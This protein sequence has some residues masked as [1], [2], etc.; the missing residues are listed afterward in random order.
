MHTQPSCA[1][2]G[3]Q[4]AKKW[5]ERRLGFARRVSRVSGERAVGRDEVRGAPMESNPVRRVVTP[6]RSRGPWKCKVTEGQRKCGAGAL[7][8][9]PPLKTR[10]RDI[11]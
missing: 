4:A 6:E 10:N 5:H 11:H 1:G 2:A 3:V 8:S 9:V 7:Q